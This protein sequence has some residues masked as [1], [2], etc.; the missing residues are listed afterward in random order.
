MLWL[1]TPFIK[2]SLI[3]LQDQA[4]QGLIETAEKMVKGDL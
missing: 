4:K 1:A 2:G 3:T